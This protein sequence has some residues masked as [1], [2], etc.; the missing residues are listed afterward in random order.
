MKTGVMKLKG[1]DYNVSVDEKG[2]CFIE[3]KTVDEFINSL[4]ALTLC[5]F[6]K[7]GGQVFKDL[8]SGEKKESYQRL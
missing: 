7:L 4:D 5:D 6:V 8:Q 2:K 3:G 1:K